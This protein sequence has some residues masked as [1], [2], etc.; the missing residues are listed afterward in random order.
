MSTK[1]AGDECTTWKNSF[2]SSYTEVNI[3]QS[4]QQVNFCSKD[5]F[6]GHI[7]YKNHSK[8]SLGDLVAFSN[9]DTDST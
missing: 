2:L 8:M 1:P 6:T 7:F 4:H 5:L 3:P 9:I